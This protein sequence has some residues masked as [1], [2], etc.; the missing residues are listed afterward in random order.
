MLDHDPIQSDINIVH[1]D[2]TFNPFPHIGHKE[3]YNQILEYQNRSVKGESYVLLTTTSCNPFKPENTKTF[4]SRL[5]NLHRGF[6]N[7][8]QS[9]IIG[10]PGNFCN[11]NQRAEQYVLMSAFDR[12]K[13]VRIA[14]GSDNFIKR[15]VECKD[16]D[17]LSQLM[18]NSGS[19]LYLSDRGD[20]PGEF[21]DALNYAN[22][23][24]DCEIVHLP[25]PTVHT[26]GTQVRAMSHREQMAFAASPYVKLD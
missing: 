13:R 19:Q 25:S 5:D 4:P 11:R 22:E 3:M 14:L 20:D 2:G 1:F 6:I 8:Q 9:L 23:N 10:I 7:D 12:D 26:S 16:G 15:V 18:L 17:P 21:S 24:F